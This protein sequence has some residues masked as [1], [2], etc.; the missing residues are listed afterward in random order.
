M[1]ILSR[2]TTPRGSDSEQLKLRPYTVILDLEAVRLREQQSFNMDQMVPQKCTGYM[3]IA[4]FH[5]P[6]S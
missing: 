2:L 5:A 4:K 3:N 1:S 6:A